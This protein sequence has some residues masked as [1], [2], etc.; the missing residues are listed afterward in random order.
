MTRF[1]SNGA[2]LLISLLFSSSIVRRGGL[3]PARS[4]SRKRVFERI[5]WI[6][7][8]AQGCLRKETQ[9]A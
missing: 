7:S 6:F 9:D 4:F 8:S 5:T 1:F 2:I 3:N